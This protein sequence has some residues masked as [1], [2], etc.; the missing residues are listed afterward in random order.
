[1]REDEGIG[2]RVATER[3]LRGLTQRQLA[4]RAHISHSLLAKVESGHAPASGAFVLAV[5][6]A[7]RVERGRLTGQPYYS[8]DRRLDAVHDVVQ[9]L[10]REVVAYRLPPDAEDDRPV[11]TVDGLR[12]AVAEVSRLGHRADWLGLGARLP[13]VLWDLRVASHSYS[14]IDRERVM[15]LFAVT[16]DATRLLAKKLG[17]KNLSS[18]LVDRYEW[19]AGQ[20]GDPLIVA[21]GEMKRVGLLRGVGEWRAAE[22][23][24]AGLRDRLEPDLANAGEPALSV[25]GFLHLESALTAARRGDADTTWDHLHEAERVAERVA[26][27]RDDYR[28][29]FNRSNVAI[30]GVSLAVELVDGRRAVER[31]RMVHLDPSTPAER[32]GH[33]HIDLARGQLL[34]GDRQAALG[35]LLTARKIAPQQTRTTRWPGRPCT[36]WPGPNAGRRTPCAAWRAGWASRT[37]QVNRKGQPEGGRCAGRRGDRQA[38]GDGAEAARPDPAPTPT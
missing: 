22:Q 4:E 1:M 8:G 20:S 17:H 37:E 2:R 25:F 15:A 29:V 14:G 38:G 19:A 7:L 3:K 11:P 35:S 5:A 32:V 24:V 18:I 30:W 16:Y 34:Y 27:D 26:P 31:A 21:V 9:D 10:R 36:R 28:L 6:R 23:V 12:A 13:E 33:H